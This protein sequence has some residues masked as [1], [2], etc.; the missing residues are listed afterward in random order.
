MYKVLY[1]KQIVCLCVCACARA[2]SALVGWTVHVWKHIGWN[3]A[4]AERSF[5]RAT[6]AMDT[7]VVVRRS[8]PAKRSS[9]G[10]NI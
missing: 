5:P 6:V 4:H 8:S 7:D 2:M 9:D 3:H 1:Q 10:R